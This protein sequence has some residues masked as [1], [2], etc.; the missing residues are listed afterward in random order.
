MDDSNTPQA[1][2]TT[3]I[4][5]EIR[6]YL[7]NILSD[8][9]ISSVDEVM[10]EELIAELFAR[11]DS[12]LTA[13]IV[14]TLPPENIDEFIKMNEDNLPEDQIQAYLMEHI[15][16]AEEQFAKFF[17][18]FRERY[19]GNILIARANEAPQTAPTEEDNEGNDS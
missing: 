5:P 11:F 7:E 4:P 9:N 12:F 18:E 8:A 10:Q 19:L 2:V 16:N 15:P 1:P 6:T 13:K 14:D 17:I 3:G